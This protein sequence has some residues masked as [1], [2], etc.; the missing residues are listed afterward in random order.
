MSKFW[1]SDIYGGPD[2]GDE[3]GEIGL[4][5]KKA[6]NTLAR[7]SYST[8]LK[9]FGIKLFV[10]GSITRTPESSGFYAVRIYPSK[11]MATFRV[12]LKQEVWQKGPNATKA[13]FRQVLPAGFAAVVAKA[14]EKKLSIA[15]KLVE[16][17]ASAL[18][19]T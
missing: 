8:V 13:F 12:V 5:V 11:G 9:E 1:M 6:L 3:V 15:D 17:V 19:A 2:A 14:K 4:A 10:S 16:D 18:G 7:K